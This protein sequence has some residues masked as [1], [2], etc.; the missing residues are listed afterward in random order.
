MAAEDSA[1]DPAANSTE[2]ST[3]GETPSTTVTLPDDLAALF[4]AL[5]ESQG[6]ISVINAT[7]V[8]GSANNEVLLQYF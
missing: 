2:D 3:T 1:S 5:K 7:E 6:Y 4:A 8:I